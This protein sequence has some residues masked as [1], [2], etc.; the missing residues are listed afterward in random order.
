MPGIDTANGGDVLPGRHVRL[1]Y[2]LS[3]IVR[4]PVIISCGDRK[5]SS[6]ANPLCALYQHSFADI[7]ELDLPPDSQH[8]SG[9]LEFYSSL[10]LATAEIDRAEVIRSC[11]NAVGASVHFIPVRCIDYYCPLCEL[12]STSVRGHSNSIPVWSRYPV[13]AM[14]EEQVDYV[15]RG[16]AVVHSARK[17]KSVTVPTPVACSAL[18]RFILG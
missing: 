6:G 1:Q 13:S 3:T 9:T 15:A 5:N 14:S 16:E 8:L 17:T 18:P 7:P 12:A 4:H 10:E 11:A 2:N